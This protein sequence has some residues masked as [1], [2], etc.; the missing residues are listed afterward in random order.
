MVEPPIFGSLLKDFEFCDDVIVIPVRDLL[1]R[2]GVLCFLRCG[3]EYTSDIDGELCLIDKEWF[4][5]FHYLSVFN[6]NASGR[7]EFAP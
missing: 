1:T 4:D 5:F 6:G 2:F 7:Y 3:S